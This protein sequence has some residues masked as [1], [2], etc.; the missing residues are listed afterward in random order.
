M[1]TSDLP[2]LLGMADRV[3]VMREGRVAGELPRAVASAERVMALA[4][5]EPS[6]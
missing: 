5:G 1:I 4:T 3:I 6:R 2:E